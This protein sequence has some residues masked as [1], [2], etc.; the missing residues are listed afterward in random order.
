MFFSEKISR[1]ILIRFCFFAADAHRQTQTGIRKRNTAYM[2]KICRKKPKL[3][4]YIL[5]GEEL[6]GYDSGIEWCRIGDKPCPCHSERSEESLIITEY[7]ANEILRSAQND[8]LRSPLLHHYHFPNCSGGSSYLSF[9]VSSISLYYIITICFIKKSLL[10]Y[11]YLIFF[12]EY[13]QD[14]C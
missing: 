11:H 1:N 13:R 5:T 8:T 9:S 7:S 14:L 3:D 2:Q 6:W 4:Y 12:L 10:L